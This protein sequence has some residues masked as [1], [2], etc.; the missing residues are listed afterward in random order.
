MRFT[1]YRSRGRHLRFSTS[2]LVAQRSKYFHWISGLRKY[3][4]SH[5][6]LCF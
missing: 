3:G 4:G 1:F 2:G 6:K 5:W